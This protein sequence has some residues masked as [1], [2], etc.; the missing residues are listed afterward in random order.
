MK[1]EA[2][3]DR[4]RGSMPEGWGIFSLG[5]REFSFLLGS[6][7]VTWRERLNLTLSLGDQTAAVSRS[8]FNQL[9]LIAQFGLDL[10]GEVSEIISPCTGN[11]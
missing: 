4:D 11:L 9:R 1:A 10:D 5:W 8:A 7:F 2:G 3:E 6:M